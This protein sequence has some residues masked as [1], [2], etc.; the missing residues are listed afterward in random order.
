MAARFLMREPAEASGWAAW[1]SFVLN[2]P[3]SEPFHLS[4][5]RRAIREAYGLPCFW[6]GAWEGGAL[7]GVLPLVKAPAPFG[8]ANLT[9][10]A[11]AVGGGIL[12]ESEEAREALA[13]EAEALGRRLGVG[14]VEL[15]GG[16]APAEWGVKEGVYAGF[17]REMAETSEK[18]L[19]Q[20]PR[21][22]RADVRK[23]MEADLKIEHEAALEPFH[24]IYSRSLRD[25]GT[26]TPSLRWMR[27]LKSAF[28]ESCHVTLVHGPAGPVAALMSFEHRDRVMPYF[29]GALP[30]ARALRAYDRLYWEEQERAALK[31]LKVFDFGRSKFGTGAFDYK[32]HWGFEPQ[33]L[34]QRYRLVR[35]SEAP[36]VNPLSPKYRRFVALWRR[37]PLWTANLLGPHLAR[38]LG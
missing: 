2:H 29:G 3:E 1:D 7:R 32:T 12:A 34:V 8:G 5:W 19:L 24:A 22:K 36:D 28:G 6:L 26:P 13:A 37:L 25:L 38:R 15:R 23:A 14:A 4:G 9:S 27:A 16:E 35:A 31:G 17:R 21:K 20:I 18:R 11:F 30:E 10:C 33:P